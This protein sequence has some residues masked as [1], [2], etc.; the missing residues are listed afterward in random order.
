M[1]TGIGVGAIVVI[2]VLFA[3]GSILMRRRNRR[4]QLD[5]E[6][7]T[8]ALGGQPYLRSTALRSGH[9]AAVAWFKKEYELGTEVP[10]SVSVGHGEGQRKTVPMRI[11]RFAKESVGEPSEEL[12]RLHAYLEPYEGS[13]LPITL[14]VQTDSEVVRL[15]VEAG[16][17][18]GLDAVGRRRWAAPWEAVSFASSSY[19]TLE[20]PD[21]VLRVRTDSGNGELA[22]ALVV[23]YGQWRAAIAVPGQA[24][25]AP[26]EAQAG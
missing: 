19:L 7:T 5:V 22:Q 9:R 25:A 23:K 1:W 13:E 20:G 21:G 16:G 24:V 8:E 4:A 3:L 11:S 12:I 6:I 26:A 18:E 10:V 2:L 17:V 14:P 15:H